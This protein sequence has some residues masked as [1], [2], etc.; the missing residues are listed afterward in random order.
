[1]STCGECGIGMYCCSAQVE[2]TRLLRCGWNP[3]RYPTPTWRP[4]SRCTPCPTSSGP[5]TWTPSPPPRDTSLPACD[6]ATSAAI[7]TSRSRWRRSSLGGASWSRTDPRGLPTT[8]RRPPTGPDSCCPSFRQIFPP[9]EN[10]AL[11]SPPFTIFLVILNEQSHDVF[12]PFLVKK[13]YLGHVWT[14]RTRYR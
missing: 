5:S 7:S 10:R 9:G 4:A 12:Y 14:T 8:T 6:S 11:R 3:P 1:M 2:L 13:L